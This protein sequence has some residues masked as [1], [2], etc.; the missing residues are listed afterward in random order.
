[1][2]WLQKW[3]AKNEA[4]T[5]FHHILGWY[6]VWAWDIVATI[7]YV[8]YNLRN[9]GLLF[10][11]SSVVWR[12]IGQVLRITNWCGASPDGQIWTNY[13]VNID[14]NELKRTS[15]NSLLY[16]K[17]MIVKDHIFTQTTICIFHTLRFYLVLK[18]CFRCYGWVELSTE[19][20]ISLSFSKCYTVLFSVL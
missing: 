3:L 15:K 2:F 14:Y 18:R 13:T 4:F 5:V 20:I 8:F 7:Q 9:V 1:M 6:R 10:V 17:L 12:L 16:Q 19:N 11:I